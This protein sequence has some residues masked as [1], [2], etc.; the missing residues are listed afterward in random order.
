MNSSRGHEQIDVNDITNVS[1]KIDWRF[2]PV[3]GLTE[4]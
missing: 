2:G 3:H 1:F 4:C